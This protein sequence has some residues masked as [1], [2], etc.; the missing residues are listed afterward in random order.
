MHRASST[1]PRRMHRAS[2][3]RLRLMHRASFPP[4]L[5]HRHLMCH[6]H[7]MCRLDDPCVRL[8][9]LRFRHTC[10]HHNAPLTSLRF[11]DRF[12]FLF[13]RH[14]APLTSLRFRHTCLHHTRFRFRFPLT[15]LRF[16]HTCLHHNRFRFLFRHHNV[17]LTSHRFLYHSP[18]RR[19]RLHPMLQP[20]HQLFQ[21]K[22]FRLPLE[23]LMSRR[24]YHH[25]QHRQCP[26]LGRFEA[27]TQRAFAA[28]TLQT[29]LRC[30]TLD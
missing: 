23:V 11:R 3:P 13:P 17:P 29:T 25:L 8:T 12:R 7:P 9:S 4:S 24:T 19:R 10:L 26:R 5:H 14:N 27:M 2:S 15:S 16:R 22:Q 28:L 20:L 21:P 18:C 30:L 1:R 6:R